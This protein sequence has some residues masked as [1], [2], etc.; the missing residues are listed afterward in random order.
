MIR[1]LLINAS[2]LVSFVYVKSQFFKKNPVT[3]KS[4]FTTKISYGI[5]SGILGIVLMK[6]SII[7]PPDI[8]IDLRH[9]AIVMSAVYGGFYSTIIAATIIAIGRITFFSFNHASM[10]VSLTMLGLGIGCGVIS[11]LFANSTIKKRWVV[12]NLF[13]MSIISILLVYLFKWNIQTAVE[14]I[15]YHWFFSFL[16]GY[17]VYIQISYISHYNLLLKRF[18][19]ESTT[20]YLTGLNN[21]R[22]FEWLLKEYTHKATLQQRKISLLFLD[23]DHFKKVNDTFGHPAGD[24]VL[25]ELGNVLTSVSRFEDIVSRN[26]G[27]EFSV[28]L[29]DCP[30]S[31]A[32]SIAERIRTT[33]QNHNFV[34]SD[35]TRIEITISI[36]ISTFLETADDPNELIKQADGALYRAKQSGRNKVCFIEN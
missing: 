9:I 34:L 13:C 17:L 5:V 33:I 29:L 6:F 35:G 4:P 21:I 2:L 23:I 14:T 22:Q 16:A 7:V 12:M 15:P 36:G 24:A 32:I 20:D 31:Q 27:E 1:D 8:L 25:R 18:K 11:K 10:V 26:G 28:L 3:L 19:E 30:H